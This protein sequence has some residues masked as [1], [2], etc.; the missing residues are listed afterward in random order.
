M[1]GNRYIRIFS[2]DCVSW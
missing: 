1:L 2:F